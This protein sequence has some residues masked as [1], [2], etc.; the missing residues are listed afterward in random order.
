[1]ILL[2]LH[3]YLIGPAICPTKPHPVT[4]D[5]IP[6][7]LGHEFSGIVEG[8]G[9]GVVNFKVGD[10]VVLEPIIFDGTCAAC[11]V[12]HLNCCARNGFVGLSGFG[13]GFAEYV[14]LDQAFWQHLPDGV[15]LKT[16]GEFRVQGIHSITRDLFCIRK[17]YPQKH[18][19]SS[20]HLCS[21]IRDYLFERPT[22]S[23]SHPCCKSHLFM[24]CH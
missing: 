9:T 14:V 24:G 13:G 4:G 17:H 6:V 12:G 1:M 20:K 7:T 21:V 11:R 16:G 22:P 15:S 3:E 2:D 5:T 8:V 23:I 10:R 18:I 19:W